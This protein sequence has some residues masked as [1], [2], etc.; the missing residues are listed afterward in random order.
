RRQRERQACSDLLARE[1][2]TPVVV[3]TVTLVITTAVMELASVYGAT[4]TLTA[5]GRKPTRLIQLHD[6]R[7]AVLAECHIDYRREGWRLDQRATVVI[8]PTGHMAG[9]RLNPPH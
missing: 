7:G 1:S 3:A 9:I 4:G 5:L 6:V 8:T 2:N